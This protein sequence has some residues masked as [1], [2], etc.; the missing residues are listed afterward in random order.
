LVPTVTDPGT[1]VVDR[2]GK[3]LKDGFPVVV[4]VHYAFGRDYNDKTVDHWVL[5]YGFGFDDDGNLYF[6]Y[7]ETNRSS[8]YWDDTHGPNFRFYLDA[9]NGWLKADHYSAKGL[10]KKYPY[11]YVT[12]LR[13]MRK[14]K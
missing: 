6:D 13:E 7:N 4:G 11:Y 2:L 3:L 14:N 9:E 5:V 10:D 8:A 1:K 12:V